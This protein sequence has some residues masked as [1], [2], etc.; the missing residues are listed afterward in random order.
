MN[1]FLNGGR[2]NPRWLSENA[3]LEAMREERP[4]TFLGTTQA[5]FN[6]LSFRVK[7][8]GRVVIREFLKNVEKLRRIVG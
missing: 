7:Q 3:T 4:F 1:D 6:A 5:A 8:F 2:K